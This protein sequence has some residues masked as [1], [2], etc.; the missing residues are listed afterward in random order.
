MDVA[1]G[2]DV[3]EEDLNAGVESDVTEAVVKICF[4]LGISELGV[5]LT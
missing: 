4:R 5:G 3:G 2:S 1:S